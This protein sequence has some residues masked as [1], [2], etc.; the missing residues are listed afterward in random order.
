VEAWD[1][2][3]T[4]FRLLQRMKA[5]KSLL[6]VSPID[7]VISLYTLTYT[8]AALVPWE[9]CIYAPMQAPD[10]QLI[11]TLLSCLA[12]ARRGDLTI[13]WQIFNRLIKRSFISISQ[14]TSLI[15]KSGSAPHT[16]SHDLKDMELFEVQYLRAVSDSHT[17]SIFLPEDTLLTNLKRFYYS[18]DLESRTVPVGYTP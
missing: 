9:R 5:P 14:M 7:Y 8:Q 10:N 4:G 1:F 16:L 15:S 3:A 13:Q 6:R 11:T 18:W 17:G 2:F 12:M